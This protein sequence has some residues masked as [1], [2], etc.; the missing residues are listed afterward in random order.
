MF[1]GVAV[2]SAALLA[3]FGRVRTAISTLALAR[4]SAM[5]LEVI[6]RPLSCQ[7]LGKFTCM[8][9]T[10]LIVSLR[11][12]KKSKRVLDGS[13]VGQVKLRV[14]F[15]EAVSDYHTS[16]PSPLASVTAHYTRVVRDND[17]RG[18]SASYKY[19]AWLERKSPTDLD[20]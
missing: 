11:V 15:W 14:H 18:S 19:S 12:C 10:R 2:L 1:G 3:W 8:S 16:K 13:I 20:R 7:V 5:F 4:E 6:D 17:L 9:R